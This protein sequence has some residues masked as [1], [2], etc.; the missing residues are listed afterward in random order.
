MHVDA[1][2]DFHY[3]IFSPNEQRGG[4]EGGVLSD[5]FF[6]VRFSLFSRPRAGLATVYKTRSTIEGGEGM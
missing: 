6:F 4:A 5:F 3:F 2:R 1:S